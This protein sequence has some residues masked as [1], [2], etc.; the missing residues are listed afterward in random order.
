MITYFGSVLPK[1]HFQPF[2][3]VRAGHSK[4][5]IYQEINK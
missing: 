1:Y 4:G 5:H 2:L 3:E